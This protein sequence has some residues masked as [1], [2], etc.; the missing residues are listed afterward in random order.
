MGFNTSYSSHVFPGECLDRGPCETARSFIPCVNQLSSFLTKAII[1]R[2]YEKN[3][4]ARAG[5]KI[6]SVG[7]QQQ[8]L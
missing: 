8:P 3:V 2:T 1:V 7:R 4:P 5:L 6:D